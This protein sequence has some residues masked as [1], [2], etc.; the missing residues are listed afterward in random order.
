MRIRS[1]I[2]CTTPSAT[3]LFSPNRRNG[4]QRRPTALVSRGIDPNLIESMPMADPRFPPGRS[5]LSGH[6]PPSANRSMKTG[7]GENGARYAGNGLGRQCPGP[8]CC[9]NGPASRCFCQPER[10]R[11]QCPGCV[12]GA[13]GFEPPNGGI[14]I[15]CLTPWL[16]PTGKDGGTLPAKRQRRNRTL[17]PRLRRYPRSSGGSGAGRL[18]AERAQ[19]R[20]Q[21]AALGD[22]ALGRQLVDEARKVLR[23]LRQQRVQRNARMLGE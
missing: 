16:R 8:I 20:L 11:R 12:A 7:N 10:R 15:R 6:A 21:N 23:E 9:R 1:S 2:S 3:I 4:R 13:G 22:L 18:A 14:K 5:R 17:R 19:R